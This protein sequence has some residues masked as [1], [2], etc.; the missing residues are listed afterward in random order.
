MTVSDNFKNGRVTCISNPLFKLVH[1]FFRSFLAQLALPH[2]CHAPIGPHQILNIRR[3][4]QDVRLKFRFPEFRASR[5]S[6]AESTAFVSM[7]EAAMNKADYIES[8]EYKIRFARKVR[9]VKPEPQAPGMNS[10]S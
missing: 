3:V 1:G 7:P 9:S 2:N 8:G 4:P 6:R 5:G 10:L